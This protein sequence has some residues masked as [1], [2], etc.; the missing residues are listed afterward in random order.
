MT[1]N[2]E[3]LWSVTIGPLEPE[4]YDYDFTVDGLHVVDP[5]NAWLKVWLRTSR[6]VLEVPGEE[7]MF[8]EEQPVPHGTIHIHKYPSKSLGVTRNLYVYTTPGYE[9]NRL[10]LGFRQ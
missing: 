9:T 7:P 10:K 5:S 4:I 3:G 1:K 2:D 8:F 6:N